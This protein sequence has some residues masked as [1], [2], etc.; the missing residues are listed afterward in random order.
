MPTTKQL[1]ENRQQETLKKYF[2]S[3]N[4]ATPSPPPR[5]SHQTTSVTA[6]APNE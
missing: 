2:G 6:E 4:K 1:E 3:L 5:K